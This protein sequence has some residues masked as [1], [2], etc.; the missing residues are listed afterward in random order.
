MA[1]LQSK[2]SDVYC[3]WET[4]FPYG[5]FLNESCDVMNDVCDDTARLLIF[6]H[7]ITKGLR[8]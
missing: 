4:S 7:E 3:E 6:V 5:K 1:T 8:L 2:C